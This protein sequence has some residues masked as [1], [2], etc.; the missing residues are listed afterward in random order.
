MAT[1]IIA[2]DDMHARIPEILIMISKG[3]EIIIEKNSRPFAKLTA[4]TA[5]SDRKKIPGLNRGEIW[6]SENF[7]D[8]L[9]DE[10]WLGEK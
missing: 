4:I 8:P 10:F 3:D 5:E 2:A 6:T 1:K 9:P 7:D